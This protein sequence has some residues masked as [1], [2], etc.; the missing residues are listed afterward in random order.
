MNQHLNS[1]F[2]DVADFSRGIFTLPR[3]STIFFDFCRL[4]IFLRSI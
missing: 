4:K 2:K 3:I 1:D